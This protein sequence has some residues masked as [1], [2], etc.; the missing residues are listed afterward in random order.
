MSVRILLSSVVLGTIFCSSSV[1]VAGAANWLELN[2]YL[3]GPRYD[4]YLPACDEDWTLGRTLPA[5][6][7]LLGL[8]RLRRL[9]R[10]RPRRIECNF[11]R[12]AVGSRFWAL[13]WSWNSPFA[14]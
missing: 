6:K 11:V 2:F 7:R 13:G 10:H 12:I 4:G 1:E 5:L 14:G 3:S 9:A 8:L